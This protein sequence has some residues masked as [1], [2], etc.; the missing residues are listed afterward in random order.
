MA[1]RPVNPPSAPPRLASRYRGDD[2]L[3]VVR[4]FG[5]E[6][7]P[8]TAAA[9]ESRQPLEDQI[10]VALK[11]SERPRTIDDLAGELKLGFLT[12]SDL[13]LDLARRNEIQLQGSPGNEVVSLSPEPTR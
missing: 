8:S 7:S 4:S 2:A 3:S 13:L 11:E 6:E 10:L 12:L 9:T 1:A 5:E